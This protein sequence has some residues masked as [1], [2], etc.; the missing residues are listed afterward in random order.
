MES[1]N[2]V[3]NDRWSTNPL[4]NDNDDEFPS[5]EIMSIFIML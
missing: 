1:I 4:E 5:Y 2:V 3:I